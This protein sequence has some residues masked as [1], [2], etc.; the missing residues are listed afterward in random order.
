MGSTPLFFACPGFASEGGVRW[1]P[2]NPGMSTREWAAEVTEPFGDEAG[3]S[4]RSLD[5]TNWGFIIA[6]LFCV[7]F[8]TFVIWGLALQ[9]PL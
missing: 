6:V 9:L 7:A 3:T 4:A 2:N 1:P 5:G 8:W